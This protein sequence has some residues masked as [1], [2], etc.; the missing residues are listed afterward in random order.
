MANLKENVRSAW[1]TLF[2]HNQNELARINRAATAKAWGL[3]PERFTTPF[4]QQHIT[5]NATGS[6]L[7]SLVGG[8]LLGLG[9]AGVGAGAAAWLMKPEKPPVP[10]TNI[11][12]KVWDSSVE[13]VV[14]PPKD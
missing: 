8:A 6:P 2:L 5:N 11:V 13:M 12:E 3:E 14:E 4:T 9:L 10:V 1:A 7:A